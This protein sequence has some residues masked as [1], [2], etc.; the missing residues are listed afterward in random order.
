MNNF[1]TKKEDGRLS[2]IK[3]EMK[4]TKMKI[5]QPKNRTNSVAPPIKLKKTK[6]Q[7]KLV[8]RPAGYTWN[9]Y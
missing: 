8:V 6:I 1:K 4:N 3:K 2:E 5:K 9:R 7:K